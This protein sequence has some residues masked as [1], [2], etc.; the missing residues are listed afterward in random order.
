MGDHVGIPGVVLLPLFTLL[1]S[2]PKRLAFESIKHPVHSSIMMNIQA[3]FLFT[4]SFYLKFKLI[5]CIHTIIV[6]PLYHIHSKTIC[7]TYFICTSSCTSIHT[8]IIVLSFILHVNTPFQSLNS[9]SVIYVWGVCVQVR[10]T[11]M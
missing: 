9:N 2:Y 5:L 1:Y 11:G 3:I 10:C 7:P 4:T 6:C 8:I